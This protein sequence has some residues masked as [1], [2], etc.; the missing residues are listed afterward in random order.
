MRLTLHDE[1]ERTIEEMREMFVRD[2]TLWR[3]SATRVA[4]VYGYCINVMK[5]HPSRIVQCPS[6]LRVPE[7]VLRVRHS[8]LRSI[9]EC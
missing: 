8:Y 3:T 1:C 2:P 5:V 9:R 6:V 4:S 7:Y